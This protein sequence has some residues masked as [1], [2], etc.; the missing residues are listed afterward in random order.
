MRLVNCV[1]DRRPLELENL[2]FF[3]V[4]ANTTLLILSYLVKL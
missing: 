4:A 2:D 3:L 1:L